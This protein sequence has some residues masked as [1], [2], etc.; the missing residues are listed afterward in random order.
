MNVGS[1]LPY[2]VICIFQL[3][4]ELK[5]LCNEMQRYKYLLLSLLGIHCHHNHES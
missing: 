1:V 4:Y 3:I 2:M 5:C